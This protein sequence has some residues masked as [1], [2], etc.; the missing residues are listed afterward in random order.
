VVHEAHTLITLNAE[1]L[2]CDSDVQP[3]LALSEAHIREYA[4]LLQEGHQLGTIVVF[5]DGLD[6]Y[7]ADGFHRV[8]AAKSIGLEELPAAIRIGTKRDAMLYACGANKHGK[9]LSN[10]DKQ[11]VVLHLLEDA[12]WGQWSDREIARH[13]GVGHAFVSRLRRSLSTEDSDTAPRTYR[14]KQG[15]VTTMETHAIGKRAAPDVPGAVST[16][17]GSDAPVSATNT[18]EMAAGNPVHEAVNQ[19]RQDHDLGLTT[20]AFAEAI[21]EAAGH[22]VTP[23]APDDSLHNGHM[24]EAEAACAAIPKRLSQ[25]F[26]LLT[27][28][29]TFPDLEQLLLDIPQDC[30]DRIDQYLDPAHDTLSRLK[31]LWK[32]HQHDEPEVLVHPRASQRVRQP[33]K[34][35]TRRKT[36]AKTRQPAQTAQATTQTVLSQPDL[37]L[38]ALRTAQQPLI[39]EALREM[40]GVDGSRLKRNVSRLVAQ[41]K[42]QETPLGYVMV[43][44]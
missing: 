35:K 17:R 23:I 44:A 26:D 16:Q 3:R 18:T 13:C 11:R 39:Y 1:V 24:K 29:A 28:L 21:D 40:P 25:L 2:R 43:S 10:V 32:K 34:R 19:A 42:V 6:Y 31:T 12:E 14:T 9:P 8:A 30:Y 38:A 20:P 5:Q 37:L 22:H 36:Q 7:L 15:T 41:K 33:A 4:A 27:A